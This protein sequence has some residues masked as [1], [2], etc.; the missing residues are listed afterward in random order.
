MKR[1]TIADIARATGVSTGAVSYALNGRPGVSE[2]TRRRILDAAAQM[3][4]APSNTARA[5]A[6]GRVGAFGLIID[7]PA[8]MLGVESFFMR[9]IAGIESE[10]ADTRTELLL[11][12]TEAP[13]AE[14][15]AYRRWSAER[16]VDGV[17]I[18]DLRRDDPR[19]RLVQE[20]GLPAVVVGGP[21]GAAG[22]PCLHSNDAEA[23]AEVVGYLAAL[24]HRRIARVAGPEGLVHTGTRTAAFTEAVH[25]AGGE[26][27]I[28]HAD[29]TADSGAR[30]TRRLLAEAPRP[31]AVVY[32]NDLMAVTG[33]GVAREM[34]VAVPDDLSVVAWDDS[35]LCRAVRPALTAV[36]RD[37]ADHGRRAARMLEGQVCGAE[38]RDAPTAPAEFIP[39]ESTGR[40]PGQRP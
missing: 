38:P 24:G 14:M 9:F 21:G 39:R 28:V 27:R 29:Y 30:A 13:E 5:L 15:E 17:L 2:P 4:W 34:G 18:V 32:D 31:T 40:A 35:V 36:G 25:A 33:L 12:V 20:V 7:R 23:T 37:V 16:R 10:L 1:P 11:R 26:P 22:L 8:P 6:E 3:G 19:V